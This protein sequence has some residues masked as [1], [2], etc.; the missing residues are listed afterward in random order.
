MSFNV[1]FLTRIAMMTIRLLFYV[2]I[3]NA[4]FLRIIFTCLL[5]STFVYFLIIFLTF[6]ALMNTTHKI[7]VFTMSTIASTTLSILESKM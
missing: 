6:E 3:L 1:I 4:I 2:V 7:I 5:V